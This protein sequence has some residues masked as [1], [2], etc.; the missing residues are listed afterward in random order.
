MPPDAA[1]HTAV[2]SY[3]HLFRG[4]SVRIQGLSRPAAYAES[5]LATGLVLRFADGAATDAEILVS[6][7]GEAVLAVSGHTTR[8]GT[9]L[10]ERTWLLR[11][12]RALGDEVEVTVGVPMA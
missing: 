2:C 1:P 12:F 4:A 7:N 9:R 3:T 11:G 6:S 5:P 10:P 8:A